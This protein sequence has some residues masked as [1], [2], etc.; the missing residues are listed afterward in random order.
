MAKRKYRRRAKT[1]ARGRVS[2]AGLK[3]IIRPVTA[4]LITGV[5]QSY[6]PNDALG[7]YADSLIPVGVGWF[8]NDPTLMTIGGYQLGIKLASGIGAPQG[9]V[10]GGVY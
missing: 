7:G 2:K 5:V 1:Y 8:M 3:S 4:G 6:V 9:S 10:G